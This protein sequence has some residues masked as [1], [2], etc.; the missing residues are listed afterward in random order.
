VSRPNFPGIGFNDNCKRKGKTYHVQTED[1]GLAKPHVI[2]HLF[3]DGGRILKSVKTSYADRVDHPDV[4]AEVR[5]LMRTQHR[6]MLE[7]IKKGELDD[8]LENRK[9]SGSSKLTL[10]S[11]VP[12]PPD[13][14]RIK[15]P[16][17][18]PSPE[19]SSSGAAFGQISV[20]RGNSPSSEP[21]VPTNIRT[22]PL[23]MSIPTPQHAED[24]HGRRRS[25]TQITQ[26]VPPPPAVPF[27]FRT[28]ESAESSTD[29]DVFRQ[30]DLPPPPANIF[31]AKP[32]STYAS[33]S[34]DAPSDSTRP[35]GRT[36]RTSPPGD[37]APASSPPNSLTPRAH[38]HGA[39]PRTKSRA[40]MT[41]PAPSS[42]DSSIPEGRRRPIPA[43]APSRRSASKPPRSVFGE[44]P[45]E[46]TLDEVILSY[47]ADDE[48]PK[49]K[50]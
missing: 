7:A 27:D 40:G 29:G 8:L 23:P 42:P 49:K 36:G 25:P 47:L 1:S 44:S 2:T 9:G 31:N 37:V 35:P 10:S 50:R 43:N 30:T 4:G 22:P 34:P 5:D 17:V 32:R 13:S 45:D 21:K 14:D 26:A 24:A 3:A 38:G 39:P 11:L 28:L 20:L 6:A 18:P 12:P 16:S 46:R 48:P 33:T 19:G 15:H 41:V